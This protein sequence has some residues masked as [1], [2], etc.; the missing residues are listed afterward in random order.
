MA[1][2]SRPD[3]LV[4]MS[5]QHNVGY[6]GFSGHPVVETPNMDALAAAGTMFDAAYTVCPLCVPARSAMLTGQL[7]SKTGIFTND[8]VIREDQ[9][10]FAHGLGAEGYDVV[11]C[12]RMHFM[13]T[14]QRHGFTRRLVGDYTP[15]LWGRYGSKRADLGPFVETSA[16][17]FAKIVGGGTSPVLEYD[18]AVVAA[19]CEYRKQDHARPQCLVVGTYAP[20]HTFVAPPELYRSY[21]ETATLPESYTRKPHYTHPVMDLRRRDDWDEETI[22]KI[23]PAYFGMITNLDAQLSEVQETWQQFTASRGRSKNSARLREATGTSRASGEDTRNR[24]RT[25]GCCVGGET[26]STSKSQ[27]VGTCRVGF[28][29]PPLPCLRTE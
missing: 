20:H 19:A 14:D 23:R 15:L 6:V 24:R 11:L 5:D 27:S 3:I 18:R 2:D 17:K 25:S 8:G 4:F 12:G 21:R 28:G 26:P 13:G 10:T 29:N 7:P 16:G 22:L 1:A 9:A